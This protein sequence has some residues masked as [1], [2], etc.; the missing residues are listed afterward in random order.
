M[1]KA[2]CLVLALVL[3]VLASPFAVEASQVS[4]FHQSWNVGGFQANYGGGTDEFGA[5]GHVWAES[6]VHRIEGV[7]ASFDHPQGS[8]DDVWI[9]SV[10]VRGIK[11]NSLNQQS[12]STWT[13]LSIAGVSFSQGAAVGYSDWNG[14]FNNASAS[15]N[16]G[17]SQVSG[18]YLWYNEYWEEYDGLT[19][20]SINVNFYGSFG[21]DEEGRML[22]RSYFGL[23]P[24][25]GSLGQMGLAALLLLWR[26]PMALNLRCLF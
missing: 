16:V 2:C 22:G 24:E 12:N 5:W 9:W 10:G 20:F 15:L 14:G 25:P 17:P 13:N 21:A 1:K 6:P 23:T 26:R 18:A 7:Y 11:N 4:S 8:S 3:A 19:H